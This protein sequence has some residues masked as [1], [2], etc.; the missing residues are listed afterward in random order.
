MQ[1]PHLP[2]STAACIAFGLILFGTHAALAQNYPLALDGITVRDPFIHADE[3][4]NTYYLYA[5]TG[6]RGDSSGDGVEAY[7]SKDLVHWSRPQLVFRRPD[8]FWG[9]K[10]IW[11]PEMHKL[12]DAY[13]LFVSFNGREGGRGTQILRA[14]S[15]AGPFTVFSDSANTPPQQRSLDGTPFVDRQGNNWLIY[16]HEWVQI[17]DGAMLA[18][19]M[20]DDWSRRTGEP[21]HLFNAS[22][23]P[24]AKPLGMQPGKY[25]TDGCFLHRTADDRLLMLWS[26][27]TGAQDR[28]YAVGIVHSESGTIRGPWRHEPKPLLADNG[29]HPMLF[30]TF[31][32]RLTLVLHQPN[33]GA[34]ARAKLFAVQ[35]AGGTLRITPWIPT[36]K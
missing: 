21:V 5:Q 27:F 1:R 7:R 12:G 9:G 3:S 15:A 18:V 29:G 13:Y 30:R 11:A 25:V 19:P 20:S 8:D 23:A 36:D 17:G 4:T 34:P 14:D 16:C 31:E 22:D 2:I 24:W 33:G 28:T 26:S 35:E 6:N 32:G 10:E